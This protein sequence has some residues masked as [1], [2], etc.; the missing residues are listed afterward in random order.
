METHLKDLPD[1]GAGRRPPRPCQEHLKKGTL[2][3]GTTSPMWACPPRDH[4]H[5]HPQTWVHPQS[6]GAGQWE[7]LVG[8][9]WDSHLGEGWQGQRIRAWGSGLPSWGPHIEVTPYS[10]F[11]PGKINRFFPSTALNLWT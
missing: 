3:E 11:S 10:T 5:G 7:R 6:Q 1:H 9:S 8:C 4:C 2:L